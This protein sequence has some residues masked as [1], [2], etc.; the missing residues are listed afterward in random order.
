MGSWRGGGRE[1]CMLG[2]CVETAA[3][4]L[5]SQPAKCKNTERK[6]ATLAW[7][8]VT[9]ILGPWC[10]TTGARARR[11]RRRSCSTRS[12]SLLQWRRAQ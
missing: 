12:G 7:E 10:A 9:M 2:R 1:L 4:A 6:A 11:K 3:T 8:S 5:E